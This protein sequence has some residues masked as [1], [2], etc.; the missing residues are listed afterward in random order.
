MNVDS[1][2]GHPADSALARLFVDRSRAGEAIAFSLPG[3]APL[4]LD[5]EKADEIFWLRAG[6][7]G[8]FD[9]H[10]AHGPRFIGLIR[11]GEPAGEISLIAE[12]PHGASVIA[13]RDSEILSLS[14]EALFAAADKD[15]ALMMELARLMARRMHSDPTTAVAGDPSVFGL[16]GMTEGLDVRGF[17]DRIAQAIRRQGY[18]AV[19]V[20]IEAQSMATEWY[21]NIENENDFV[22]YAAEA[23]EEAWKTFAARQ[24]DHLFRMAR[25]ASKPDRFAAAAIPALHAEKPADLVLIENRDRF[26]PVGAGAWYSAVRP[27]R[28]FHLVRRRAADIDRLA[29]TITGSAVGLAL[30]GGAARAFAHVGAI[31]ALR[32][33][34]IPI[35]FVAGSSMGAIIGAG[36]AMQWDGDELD[37]RLRK[38]FVESS[39]VADFALPLVALSRGS[40]MRGRLAEHF[41]DLDICD[42]PLPF[43]C[44][45]SNLTSGDLKVHRQ[46]LLREALAASAA[47]PGVLP[48]VVQG[49]DILVDGAIMN[50]FP[51]DILRSIH[52][53]PIVG[54]DVTLGRSIDAHDV[55]VASL[56]R[57]LVAGDWRKGPPI[58]SLLM[59]AATMSGARDL[60]ISRR[61]CDVLIQPI[62]DDIEIRDWRAYGRAAAAGE[63]AAAETLDR[64]AGDV[65][66]LRRR[67]RR[68]L[69][70]P[71]VQD[72]PRLA[73]V[74][75]QIDPTASL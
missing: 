17:A 50:N 39:P 71:P 31:R 20:G 23:E 66:D 38:A 55:T 24:A 26:A 29:R 32:A 21:S 69:P 62:V 51:A 72:R 33:R 75:R 11:P 15:P 57:W 64:L 65:V 40:L 1:V 73:G 10:D 47:L 37:H 16:I 49:E 52:S 18:H 70:G 27:T 30:S 9:L 7:L 5:G 53:G 42:L 13:L 60:A 59:R 54:V 28:I 36:V 19:V 45:S 4:F 46:G 44:V 56:W 63:R 68:S 2:A 61:A 74:D 43:F 25:A 22:L 34:H 3:G 12:T 8:A 35:D 14:R 58:V 6:R 67:S 48:P 41:G